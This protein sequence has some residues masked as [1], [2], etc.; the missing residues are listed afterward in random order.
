MS[1]EK[2]AALGL[3]QV[4]LKIL[5]TAKAEMWMEHQSSELWRRYSRALSQLASDN[6][7]AQPS[8]LFSVGLLT[9][10]QVQNFLFLISWR[11]GRGKCNVPTDTKS[12]G[13]KFSGKFGQISFAHPK[14]AWSYTY[15]DIDDNFNIYQL[16][17][18]LNIL[19]TKNSMTIKFY[20]AFYS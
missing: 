13:R 9:K 20:R 17:S 18:P 3:P 12:V 5:L 16:K 19:H 10:F 8:V 2:E 11:L 7:L 6:V 1:S 4:G 15:D 14:N